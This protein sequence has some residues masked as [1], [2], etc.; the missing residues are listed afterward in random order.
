[1]YKYSKQTSL[2]LAFMLLFALFGLTPA[3]A[4][5]SENTARAFLKAIT[6]KQSPWNILTKKSQDSLI[7][8]SLME[9]KKSGLTVSDDEVRTYLRNELSNS[10]SEISTVMWS[11]VTESL[12][13]LGDISNIKVKENGNTA[14]I[15]FSDGSGLKMLKENGAW[16]IALMESLGL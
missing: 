16:K 11:T 13:D 6:T 9:A 14:D 12:G 15:I 4:S 1:M 5:E 10:K 3:Q 2:F 8:L 7:E